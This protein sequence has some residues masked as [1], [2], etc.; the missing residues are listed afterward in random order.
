MTRS[1]TEQHEAWIVEAFDGRVAAS[2]ARRAELVECATCG[3][4]LADFDALRD[5]LDDAGRLE[6][7]VLAEVAAARGGAEARRAAEQARASIAALAGGRRAPLRRVLVPLA[8]A[9]AV[10]LGAYW[11]Y[12]HWGADEPVSQPSA[13]RPQLGEHGVLEGLTVARGP[14]GELELAWAPIEDAYEYDLELRAEGATSGAAL[15]AAPR[16]AQPRCT[17][18]RE[19]AARLP[20]RVVALVHARGASGER[21]QPRELAFALP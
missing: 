2:D 8:A 7:E 18:A 17:I 3:P 1:H 13:L 9:A 5:G 21:L 11:I 16:L 15:A 6:R 12:T 19:Q 10:V 4:L 14:S 20:T